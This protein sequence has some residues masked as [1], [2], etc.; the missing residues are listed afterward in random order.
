[1]AT[2]R[3]VRAAGLA[4]SL[5]SQTLGPGAVGAV[6]LSPSWST[7]CPQACSTCLGLGARGTSREKLLL[8]EGPH[9]ALPTPP[10]QPAQAVGAAPQC[11][12][13]DSSVVCT[14][15]WA[16]GAV[17]RPPPPPT[18]LG[19]EAGALVSRFLAALGR[20]LRERASGVDLG[21]RSRLR[22]GLGEGRGV[23]AFLPQSAP[24]PGYPP[25]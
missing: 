14:V 2:S 5:C 16:V 4:R 23:L 3:P 11:P 9:P 15:Q 17:G 24:S 1:M 12:G 18:P 10:L 21:W 25:P 13:Q 22:G 19:Q 8:E 6:G 7:D 20:C